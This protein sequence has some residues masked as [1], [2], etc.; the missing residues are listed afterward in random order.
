MFSSAVL[1]IHF[2]FLCMIFFWRAHHRPLSEYT[3]FNIP[4][5]LFH[6]N[7]PCKMMLDLPNNKNTPRTRFVYTR[8]DFEKKKLLSDQEIEMIVDK[9]LG[10]NYVNL[11]IDEP[12]DSVKQQI[13]PSLNYF[14]SRNI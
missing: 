2:S 13:G 12:M 3:L 8:M 5:T 4:I 1:F 10:I 11:L 14:H 6:K 7:T 9:N